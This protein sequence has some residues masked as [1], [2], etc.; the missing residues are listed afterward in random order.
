MKKILVVGSSNTDMVVKSIKLPKP[1]ETVLGGDFFSFAGGKGAN[2]AVAAAK[3]NGDVIFMAKVGQDLYG[4]AAIEGFKRVGI[5]TSKILKDPQVHSGVA[6]IMVDERG[7]NCIS[8]ASGANNTFTESDIDNLD[9][10]LDDVEFVLIQLE[11]PMD[12]VEYLVEKCESHGKKVV[13]NPAPAANLSSDCLS[14]LEIITPNEIETEILTGIK[15]QDVESAKAAA[16]KLRAHGVSTV[17]ITMGSKGAYFSTETESGLIPSFPVEAVD[18]TAAG[19]TFNGALVVGLNE[20]KDLKEAI[21]FASK[22]ASISVTRMGAQ[23]SQ[24]FR[25]EIT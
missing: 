17:I 13:L 1:G 19:D 14:K 15:I 21:S 12:I 11:I 3:L 8:V 10:C 24:P 7:E 2:Q 4:E 9:D 23:D 18:T 16:E 22:A 20:G 5:D 6:L 25:D